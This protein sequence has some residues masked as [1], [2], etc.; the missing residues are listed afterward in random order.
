MHAMHGKKILKI[1]Q[2]HLIPSVIGLPLETR[3]PDVTKDHS[4]VWS[5]STDAHR[6]KTKSSSKGIFPFAIEYTTKNP[7]QIGEYLDQVEKTTCQFVINQ[8]TSDM[9]NELG[10][11]D[12]ADLTKCLTFGM[13]REK[14]VIAYAIK[15]G[16]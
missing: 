7:S 14:K 12:P 9:L 11:D 3:N 8:L 5:L 16:E 6:L 1:E 10:F 4:T 13:K 2:D 15:K